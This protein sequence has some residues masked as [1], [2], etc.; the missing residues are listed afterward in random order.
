MMCD[1]SGIRLGWGG[2][3]SYLKMAVRRKGEIKSEKEGIFKE[4]L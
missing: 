2:E 4:I 3:D 1:S